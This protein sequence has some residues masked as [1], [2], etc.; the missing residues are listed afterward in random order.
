MDSK[1]ILP[2]ALA[3]ACLTLTACGWLREGPD[4]SDIDSAV[5]R[6]LDAANKGGLNA[7]AG[8]PLPTADRVALVK[9][10]GDC[11]EQRS[12][13]GSRAFTCNVSIVLRPD[14]TGDEGTTLHAE[15]QFA[16]DSGGRWQTADIDRSIV[17]GTAKS[18]IDQ[19][20]HALSGQAA[21]K[22]RNPE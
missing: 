9:P 14:E 19:A 6:A 22:P 7:L 18:L 12:T 5:R 10:D 2:V 3:L 11:A 16:K 8:N 1:N 4:A 20:S 13:G 17:V 15:L 21:S